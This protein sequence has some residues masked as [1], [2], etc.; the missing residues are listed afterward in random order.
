LCCVPAALLLAGGLWLIVHRTRL[1]RA[2]RAVSMDLHAAKLMGIPTDRVISRTFLLGGFLGGIAGTLG[3]ITATV[4]PTMGF[5]PGLNA[6]IAAVVGGIGS[7]GGA[8]VGGFIIGI[9]QY[10]VVWA[11]VSTG[12]RDVASLIILILILVVRPQGI[13]GRTEREKV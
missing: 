13:L 9:V 4:S 7:I 6:F 5:L 11:G 1:G 8:L 2:M 12:Y 3:G 10:M